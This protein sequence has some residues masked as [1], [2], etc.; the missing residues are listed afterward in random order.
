M[1]TEQLQALVVGLGPVLDAAIREVAHAPRS[2]EWYLDLRAQ[3]DA[4]TISPSEFA[5]RVERHTHQYTHRQ[6][7]AFEI[8]LA[9]HDG[10]LPPGGHGDEDKPDTDWLAL[11]QG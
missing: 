4:G 7:L 3:R 9:R 8:A 11:V 1:T 5:A 6:R 2:I 10:H